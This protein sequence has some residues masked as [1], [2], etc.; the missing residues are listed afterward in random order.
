MR[1]KERGGGDTGTVLY[2]RAIIL[3]RLVGWLVGWLAHL[4][5][6]YTIVT[7]PPP[8]LLLS[9]RLMGRPGMSPYKRGLRHVCAVTGFRVIKHDS[10]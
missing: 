5:I 7:S 6:Q 2:I 4:T 8:Y 9:L 10:V 3:H 1:E